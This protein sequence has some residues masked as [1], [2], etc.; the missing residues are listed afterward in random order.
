MCL[1]KDEDEL[2]TKIKDR[3]SHVISKSLSGQI[4]SEKSE[5]LNLLFG[6]NRDGSV[7]GNS[8]S[9]RL[10]KFQILSPYRGSYFGTLGINVAIKEEYRKTHHLDSKIYGK[11]IP[12]THSDKII[13]TA[14]QY[15]YK[16][17]MLSNGSIGV[18]NNI[19]SPY[20]HRRFFFSDLKEPL[21]VINS[22]QYEPAYAITIHKSQGS[23]FEHTF[24]VIPNKKAL[25]SRELVYTALTRSTSQVT[26]FLQD[27]EANILE[28]ARKR[29]DIQTRLT[30]I[31]VSPENYKTF[32][33]PKS[34]VFVRSKIEYII[35][36]ELE[37]RCIEFE[38]EM[39]HVFLQDGKEITLKPDFTIKAGNKKF[40]L[41]HLGMLDRQDYS[42]NWSRR[43]QIY[44]QNNLGDQLIT[45]DDINGIREEKIIELVDDMMNHT[46]QDTKESKFSIHHYTLY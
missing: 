40:F 19:G 9:M 32:Y 25:L 24:V 4:P 3:L 35:F 11:P 18:V 17:L 16:G 44:E 36:K 39:P 23:E 8:Q 7:R 29:S 1:W 37:K 28:N 15:G 38:Y 26:L 12:F 22:E 30:S 34:G 21:K 43:R 31:F 13:S 20:P 6:L 33:E 41:E 5:Q 45:T 10:D 14:N 27:D 42:E 46:L 2:F